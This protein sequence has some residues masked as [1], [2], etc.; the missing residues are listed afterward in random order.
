MEE[1]VRRVR[2]MPP[3]GRIVLQLQALLTTA[4][5]RLDD[6]SCQLRLDCS[7]TARV[8]RLANAAAFG[9]GGQCDGIDEAISR[10]G[11]NQVNSIVSA[12]AAGDLLQEELSFYRLDSGE[13][14]KR[15]LAVALGAS[16]FN[17]KAH[18]GQEGNLIFTAGL[19]HSLGKTV[20]NDYFLERHGA[21]LQRAQHREITPAIERALFGHDHAQVGAAVLA[22]WNFSQAMVRLVRDHLADFR[23]LP[24]GRQIAVL[25]LG[26]EA[27]P[28]VLDPGKSA[29][30]L[31]QQ[32]AALF[33]RLPPAKLEEA[34][35][36]TRQMF[37]VFSECL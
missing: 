7:L 30:A 19:L 20:L 37:E 8:L 17:Q 29:Y 2:A 25:R 9:G 27:V 24:H 10:L 28:W 26:L 21:V 31:A 23:T 18:F 12:L 13:L 33:L 22:K 5:T 36:Y 3:S 1:L 4:N 16:A 6:V 35:V 11:F 34:L 15:S 14:L 32:P